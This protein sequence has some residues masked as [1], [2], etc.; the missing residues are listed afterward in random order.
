MDGTVIVTGVASG[1]GAAVATHLAGQGARVAGLDL[2]EFEP[3]TGGIAMVC[4]VSDAAAVDTAV[5]HISQDMG[6]IRGLVCCAGI[7]PSAKLSGRKG[8]HDAD[9][10]AK[11]MA[12][13]VMGTFHLMRAVAPH[14]QGNAPDDKGQRGVMISTASIAAY[15]GQIGQVAYAASKGAVA[16]MTLPLARELARDGIRVASIAPGV[17]NTPMMQ[18]MPD[19]VQSSIAATIPF[20]QKLGDPEDFARLVGHIFE[21]T[22]L[23]G[24]VIRLDGAL[25]MAGR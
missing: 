19:E 7:A 2:A 16:S 21:N 10:F 3:P 6:D 25:R 18:A 22:T 12:V 8:P 14:M 4:D 5:S 11:V 9:L 13:N 15:E 23:N 24:D 17:F 1:L 20:P